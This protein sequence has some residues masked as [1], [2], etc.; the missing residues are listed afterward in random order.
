MGASK[1]WFRSIVNIRSSPPSKTAESESTPP[2]KPNPWKLLTS[3]H[4]IDKSSLPEGED[5]DEDHDV[6]LK[7]GNV[8]DDQTIVSQTEREQWA[9]IRI[10]TAFRALLARRALCALKGLARL[11]TA[12]NG[13]NGRKQSIGSMRSIQAFVRTQARIHMHRSLEAKDDQT[14]M[15]KSSSYAVESDAP[16]KNE[17]GWCNKIGSVEEIQARVQQKQEAAIKRERALAYAFSN[18]WRANKRINLEAIFDYGLDNSTWTWIWLDRW[19]NSENGQV[20][21]AQQKSENGDGG[22][23]GER[24]EQDATIRKPLSVHVKKRLKKQPRSFDKPYRSSYKTALPRAKSHGAVGSGL[25]L[26]TK[27]SANAKK[28]PQNP[29]DI[30]ASSSSPQRVMAAGTDQQQR[31]L[32]NVQKESSSSEVTKSDDA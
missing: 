27:K 25:L 9:A 16:R 15:K 21:R 8:E 26:N 18:Q 3:C 24:A 31:V 20:L 10:Q 12:L 32:E 14:T 5:E 13:Q 2:R 17:D 11:Q 22:A 29:H 4:V 1:K 6:E 19:V 23:E 7:D 30:H 28:I